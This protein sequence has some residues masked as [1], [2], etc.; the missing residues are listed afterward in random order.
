MSRFH[1]IA[2]DGFVRWVADN[3]DAGPYHLMWSNFSV[4][5]SFGSRRIGIGKSGSIHQRAAFE[6]SKAAFEALRLLGAGDWRGDEGRQAV[7]LAAEA[8]RREWA[9]YSGDIARFGSR[10]LAR[11]RWAV[12]ER[13][14]KLLGL[15]VG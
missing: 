10:S 15:P 3:P 4:V 9:R 11:Y 12:V 8:A 14:E 13:L 2:N 7:K 5:R 1:L 6:Q